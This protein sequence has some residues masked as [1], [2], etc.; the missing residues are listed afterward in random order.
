MS[1]IHWQP[2]NA[3]ARRALVF[4]LRGAI[5]ATSFVACSVDTA[6]PTTLPNAG[7]SSAGSGAS[8]G[9]AAAAGS[10]TAGASAG[11]AGA[12]VSGAAG[13]S[14]G[15]V[16]GDAGGV[17][18]IGG[19]GGSSTSGA[20][21]GGSTPSGGSEAGGG[22]TAGAGGAASPGAELNGESWTMKCTKPDSDAGAGDRCWL[23]PAGQD[24]CPAAGYTSLDKTL[25][26]GGIPGTTYQVTL[27]FEGTH[28]AGDYSGGT[29][30]ANEFLKGATHANGGLH[31]WL[32]MEVSSPA[33]TYNPNAG[34][35]GGMVRTY[36]YKVTIPID[37]GATVRMKAFDIDCLMHR[38]CQNNVLSPCK[39]YALAGI[40]PAE[41]PIDGSF[42]R[43]TVESVTPM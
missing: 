37:G 3:A 8:A 32:S 15:G 23:L 40:S 35:S 1:P 19:V 25:H 38:Y 7:A 4:A 41:S 30:V 10:A 5:V 11:A 26:F 14:A 2:L 27:H 22:A 31:T 20:A 13:V 21:H 9:V 28:E 12:S 43:M 24:A 16:A 36:D 33:A 39:G 6:G 29:K 18:N 17:Q 42:L 34:G